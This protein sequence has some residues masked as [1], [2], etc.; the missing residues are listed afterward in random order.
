MKNKWW[1][2]QHVVI[3]CRAASDCGKKNRIIFAR[4]FSAY[5]RCNHLLNKIIE[6]IDVLLKAQKGKEEAERERA[7]CLAIRAATHSLFHTKTNELDK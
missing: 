7:Y 1:Q 4:Y 5:C 6:V 3:C 2:H